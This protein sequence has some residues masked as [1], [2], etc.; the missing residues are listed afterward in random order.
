MIHFV[1]IFSLEYD[2]D[3]ASFFATYYKQFNFDYY[4]LYLHANRPLEK[5][6]INR[7]VSFFEKHGYHTQLLWGEYSSR[8]LQKPVYEAYTKTVPPDTYIVRADA[9][10]FQDVPVDYRRLIENHDIIT[11]ELYDKYSL[12]L[13]AACEERPLS[14]QYPYGGDF[15]KDNKFQITFPQKRSKILSARAD[16]PVLYNGSHIISPE[17]D[18]KNKKIVGPFRVYHYKFRHCLIDKMLDRPYYTMLYIRQY[19]DFFKIP[20]SEKLQKRLS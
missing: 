10:E 4:M 19:I 2:T 15:E 6:F 14:E 7:Y 13:S 1:S 12:K 3:L 18:R 11:G 17:Y 5:S 9:D 8:G 20:M 16:V